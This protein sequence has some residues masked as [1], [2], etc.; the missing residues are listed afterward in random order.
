MLQR[1]PLILSLAIAVLLAGCR[2]SSSPFT[3]TDAIA[4]AE[5]APGAPIKIEPLPPPRSGG[6]K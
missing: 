4:C 6:R 5:I 3:C 2:S 1:G